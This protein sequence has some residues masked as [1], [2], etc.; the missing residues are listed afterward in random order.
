MSDKLIKLAK[1]FAYKYKL[2]NENDPPSDEEERPYRAW[3]GWDVEDP[4]DYLEEVKK[5][6][7]DLHPSFYNQYPGEDRDDYL[8]R[9]E[10]IWEILGFGIPFP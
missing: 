6:G 3:G 9:Q 4:V 7:L 2:A 10:D 1:K 5:S 8:Q